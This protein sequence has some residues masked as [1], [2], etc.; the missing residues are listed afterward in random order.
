MS[1]GHHPPLLRQGLSLAGSL[2][3]PQASWL[4]STRD[5]P[6][7]TPQLW[8]HECAPPCL[9]FSRG[10]FHEDRVLTLMSQALYWLRYLPSLINTEFCDYWVEKEARGGG[11]WEGASLLYL[12]RRPEPNGC[13]FLTPD[14]FAGTGWW[15]VWLNSDILALGCCLHRSPE[16][17]TSAS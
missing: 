16:L 10:F 17:N 14:A 3:V 2:Q 4:V 1:F 7:S 12:E 8:G 13:V 11:C 9:S 15:R 5:P 6:V